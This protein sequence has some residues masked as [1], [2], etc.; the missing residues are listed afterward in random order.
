MTKK[1]SSPKRSPEADRPIPDFLN[2]DG[3]ISEE[4]QEVNCFSAWGVYVHLYEFEGA[5]ALHLGA[6]EEC[7]DIY[8]ELGRISFEDASDIAE[9]RLEDELYER[10]WNF[11]SEMGLQNLDDD[12]RFAVPEDADYKELWR[13]ERN[14]EEVASIEVYRWKSEEGVRWLAVDETS[15]LVIGVYR[16]RKAMLNARLV[17]EALDLIEE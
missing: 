1:A 3:D 7:D 4:Y 14:E 11:S 13:T 10:G 5:F 2:E 16:T 6:V 12:A 8:E 15:Q 17:Q 9:G